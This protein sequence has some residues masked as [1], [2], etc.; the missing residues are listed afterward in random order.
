MAKLE[1][2]QE[3]KDR[4]TDILETAINRAKYMV[5]LSFTAWLYS[6][7]KVKESPGKLIDE[8][9]Q[10]CA[11]EANHIKNGEMKSNDEQL[12]NRSD[13]EHVD[14]KSNDEEEKDVMD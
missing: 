6:E 8:Y 14:S 7:G 1:L 12:S 13:D 3:H 11:L 5:L 9:E 10:F 2:H 4:I